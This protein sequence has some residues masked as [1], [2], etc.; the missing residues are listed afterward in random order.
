MLPL[1]INDGFTNKGFSLGRRSEAMRSATVMIW[2][3]QIA[4]IVTGEPPFSSTDEM[5]D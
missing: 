1:E 4:V 5:S 3:F 2:T